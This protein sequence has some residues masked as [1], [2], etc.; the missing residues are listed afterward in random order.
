LLF[1]VTLED[2]INVLFCEF[3][4]S[5]FQIL[6]SHTCYRESCYSIFFFG[7]Y[8]VGIIMSQIRFI[9]LKKCLYIKISLSLFINIYYWG[10][11][12]WILN[13]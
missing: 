8:Y 10:I 6:T 5:I 3:E 13:W 4:G 1:K 7:T 2:A 12:I 11:F 9:I